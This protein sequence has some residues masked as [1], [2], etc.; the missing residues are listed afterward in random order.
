MA[1]RGTFIGEG[2][3][4]GRGLGRVFTDMD[5]SSHFFVILEARGIE[6]YLARERVKFRG[7]APKRE[8]PSPVH[9]SAPT[10]F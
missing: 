5:N 3:V 6:L 1:L 7:G 8:N 2:Y 9:A 10:L 4:P